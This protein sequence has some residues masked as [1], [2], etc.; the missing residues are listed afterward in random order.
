M[1]AFICC[2]QIDIIGIIVINGYRNYNKTTKKNGTKT[3]EISSNEVN[4]TQEPPEE[5]EKKT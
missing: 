4:S 2:L 5:E 3:P 1:S